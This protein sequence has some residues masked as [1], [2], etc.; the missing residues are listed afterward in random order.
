MKKIKQKAKKG[1]IQ[2]EIVEEE[3]SNRKDE[4]SNRKRKVLFEVIFLL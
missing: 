1:S 2:N 4:K 3:K